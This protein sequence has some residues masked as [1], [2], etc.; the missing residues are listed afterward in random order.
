MGIDNLARRNYDREADLKVKEELQ[1]AGIPVV[2]LYGYINNEVKT[3]YIGVL[4]G[5]VFI[6]AWTYWIVRGN[7]PLERANELYAKYKDLQIRVAGHAGNPAPKGWTRNK[8][9]NKLV[10]PY[11]EQFRNEEITMDEFIKI[12]NEILEQGEQVITSYHID[13][14]LG[15]CKFVE[16]IKNNNIQTEIIEEA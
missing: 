16:F 9:Y 11:V 8:D 13:T 12:G 14:Q 4:N 5:F 2:D 10:A 6:R 3:N 1:I 7:M 15:L